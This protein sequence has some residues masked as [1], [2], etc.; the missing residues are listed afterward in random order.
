MESEKSSV[1]KTANM[2][3]T[4]TPRPLADH[5]VFHLIGTLARFERDLIRSNR[6][7]VPMS[8]PVPVWKPP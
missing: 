4:S 6:A 2:L 8:G 7:R 5:L 1:G 3:R